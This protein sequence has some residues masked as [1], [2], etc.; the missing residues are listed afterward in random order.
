M[1]TQGISQTEAFDK[2]KNLLQKNTYTYL[3]PEQMHSFE[4]GYRSLLYGGRL[5]IDG[6]VYYNFYSNFIA[7]IEAS[8]P[9]TD[10][11]DQIPASLYDKSKA[12]YRLWTNSKSVVHNYGAELDVRYLIDQRYSIFANGSYQ[13][14]KRTSQNDGLED[15]FNTP[16]WIV[17]AGLNANNIIGTFGFAVSVKY[18]NSYYWQSFLINGTV[19]SIFTANADVNYSF[20]NPSIRISLGA[21]NIFNKYYYS[22]LGGPQIGGMY[23]T[24]VTYNLFNH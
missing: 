21:S 22:I 18:Q 12:R 14:L 6:D 17:N 11:P 15:G 2:N 3:K 8:I 5:M 24:T 1:N 19:P 10:D 9:N 4:V 7:Q 20:A 13:A 16:A 23:Y